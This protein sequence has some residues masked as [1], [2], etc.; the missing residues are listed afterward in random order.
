ME[1]A[2]ALDYGDDAAVK[3]R[4]GGEPVLVLDRAPHVVGTCTLKGFGRA[5]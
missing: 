3:R 5:S 1:V 4:D 2:E